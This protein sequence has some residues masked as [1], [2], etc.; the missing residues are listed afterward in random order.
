[1]VQLN[2]EPKLGARS[3]KTKALTSQRTPKNLFA[4]RPAVSSV[5]AL[6][7]NLHRVTQPVAN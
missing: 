1:M 2:F 3:P 7:S 6:G 4:L 5:L